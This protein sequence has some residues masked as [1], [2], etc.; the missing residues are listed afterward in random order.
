M[1]TIRTRAAGATIATAVA[2]SMLAIVP[3]AQAAPAYN[4]ERKVQVTVRTPA[5]GMA[6]NR[7]NKVVI[8]LSSESG[9]PNGLVEIRFLRQDG[10][11]IKR[12]TCRTRGNSRCT[13]I[14]KGPKRGK[15]GIVTAEYLGNKK[16]EDETA[17]KRYRYTKRKAR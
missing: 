5:N 17:S 12:K 6:L 1:T 8:R 9:Q 7:R 16:Y 10:T 11:V 4:G 15:K 13:I 2:G 3:A 14:F